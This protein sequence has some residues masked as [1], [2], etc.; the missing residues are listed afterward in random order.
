M[1]KAVRYLKVALIVEAVVIPV[2][3]ISLFTHWPKTW[4]GWALVLLGGPL[5]WL[6][7]EVVSAWAR[8]ITP[9]DSV[10][11]V[12]YG[13]V[14]LLLLVGGYLLFSLLLGGYLRPHFY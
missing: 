14:M 6:L 13:I 11:T 3:L 4:L 2:F 9:D 5:F 12:I 8:E 7:V 1:L 10:T